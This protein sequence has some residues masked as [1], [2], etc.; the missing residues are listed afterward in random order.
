L[1][2][3]KDLFLYCQLVD[4]FPA[5]FQVVFGILRGVLR[6]LRTYCTIFRRNF[7]DNPPNPKWETPVSIDG[8]C[9]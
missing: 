1:V 5:I 3:H 4:K 8:I 7:N 6:F 9:K 2:T